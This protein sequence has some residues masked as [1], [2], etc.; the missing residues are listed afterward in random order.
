MIH[1][2]KDIFVSLLN[3]LNFSFGRF[4]YY[5]CALLDTHIFVVPSSSCFVLVTLRCSSHYFFI[6]CCKPTPV[7]ISCCR[8]NQPNTNATTTMTEQASEDQEIRL[9]RKMIPK[10]ESQIES[11]RDL[12][13]REKLQSRLDHYTQKL[14]HKVMGIIPEESAPPSPPLSI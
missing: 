6:S 9:I 2:Y 5:Y 3:I 7:V 11:C 12:E 8:V 10:L 4:L 1:L 14:R 13:K